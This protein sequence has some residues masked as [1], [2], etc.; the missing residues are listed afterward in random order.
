MFYRGSLE[1]SFPL[2]KNNTFMLESEQT[3]WNIVMGRNSGFL[4]VG[5]SLLDLP[6]HS[7]A[8]LG[9]VQDQ[10]PEMDVPGQFLREM[11]P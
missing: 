9:M 4:I 3:T 5:P 10:D 1:F 2:T 8:V 11:A 6:W 7:M